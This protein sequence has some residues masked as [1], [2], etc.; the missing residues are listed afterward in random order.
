MSDLEIGS[1]VRFAERI[2][3]DLM[4]KVLNEHGRDVFEQI[5][6]MVGEC[7]LPWT[8]TLIGKSVIRFDIPPGTKYDFAEPETIILYV[9]VEDIEVVEKIK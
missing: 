7:I 8:D 2:N 3:K 5:F 4:L 9:G 1:K 6:F